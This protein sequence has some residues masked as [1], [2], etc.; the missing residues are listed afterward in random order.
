MLV[1]ILFTT[2]LKGEVGMAVAISTQTRV[3]V[4]RGIGRNFE[5]GS[6]V[7]MHGQVAGHRGWVRDGDV[8]PPAEGGSF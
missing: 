6:D 2:K 3:V 1:I 7:A 4:I 8:P 5:R